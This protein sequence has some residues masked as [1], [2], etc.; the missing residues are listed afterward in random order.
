M[1]SFLQFQVVH[2]RRLETLQWGLFL[3][4][5]TPQNLWLRPVQTMQDC[6]S[7]GFVYVCKCHWW[8]D[9]I[10]LG[11][12]PIYFCKT[13]C[14]V[15]LKFSTWPLVCGWHVDINKFLIPKIWHI[16]WKDLAVILLLLSDDK[17]GVNIQEHPVVYKFYRS[18]C[19]SDKFERK[20]T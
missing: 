13:Y 10:P 1:H 20:G 2:A 16:F 17:T 5:D 11:S 9:L 15:M 19:G 12:P 18:L 14:G 7:G 3:Q 8:T 6:W 4:S